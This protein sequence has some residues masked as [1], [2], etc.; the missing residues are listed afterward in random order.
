MNNDNL[1]QKEKL[2]SEYRKQFGQNLQKELTCCVCL[3][4]L[5]DPMMCTNCHQNFC[6]ECIKKWKV[7]NNFCPLKCKFPIYTPNLSLKHI[8]L[9]VLNLKDQLSSVTDKNGVKKEDY[10]YK[11]TELKKPKKKENNLKTIFINDYSEID[12]SYDGPI[13][14][15][16][17][18]ID[19]K[20]DT[21]N[22]SLLNYDNHIINL[23]NK[24]EIQKLKN[25]NYYLKKEL[26]M[27]KYNFENICEIKEQL[28][29]YKQTTSILQ[30][31]LNDLNHELKIIKGKKLN[32]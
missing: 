14:P 3:E 10:E 28:L 15:L 1:K 25:Q 21:F 23:Q 27:Q 4:L 19:D 18:E 8:L 11:K 5:E 29:Y 20:I 16:F 13:I 12:D 9:L 6:N 22:N 24:Y 30:E 31:K 32:K 2:I 7:N 26:D 17:D